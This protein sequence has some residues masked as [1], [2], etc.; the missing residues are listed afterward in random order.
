MPYYAQIDEN[1]VCYHVVEAS[2]IIEQEDMIEIESN[3]ISLLDKKR[4]GEAW[5]EAD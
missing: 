3:D 1:D 4:V 5:E 2:G